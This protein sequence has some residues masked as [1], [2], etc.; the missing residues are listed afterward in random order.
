MT[1]AIVCVALLGLL[2]FALG[3]GVSLTR[4]RSGVAAGFPNDPADPLYKL[5][6]A[7]GNTTEYAAMLA[8]L[9]LLVGSRD[10]SPWSLWA[11]GIAV[12]G[13]Y[14]IAAGIIL[15]PTLEKANPL[16]FVGALTTYLAGFALCG[17]L[18]ASL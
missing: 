15:S 12:A 5:V 3:F 4:G 1:V 2:V 10:P 7:H 13:R 9:I 11:M 16:R 18:L 17:A 14:L 8:V 6:R